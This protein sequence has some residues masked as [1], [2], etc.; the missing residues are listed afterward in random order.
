MSRVEQPVD[1]CGGEGLGSVEVCVL[2]E[3]RMVR[4]RRKTQSTQMS[5]GKQKSHP[6]FSFM[7]GYSYHFLGHFFFN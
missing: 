6:T 2:Y 5:A 7:A 1:M 4:P 3:L